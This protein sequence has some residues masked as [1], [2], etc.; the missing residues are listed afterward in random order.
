L[1]L[2]V[3]LI[4]VTGTTKLY[5]NIETK[6]TDLKKYLFRSESSLAKRIIISWEEM[7]QMK[8]IGQDLII[9]VE[10]GGKGEYML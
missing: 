10:S 6:P 8:A 4:P 5:I 3:N 7:K 1:N 9:A 2:N